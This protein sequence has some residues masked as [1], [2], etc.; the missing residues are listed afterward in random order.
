MKQYK[1]IQVALLAI[2]LFGWAG[3]SQ[4]EEEV[5]GNA[6]NGIVLNV[7][8]TGLISNEPSTRTEDTGFVTTFTQGDQIGLFAVKD[9]AILDEINNMPFTFNGSS[10][11]GKPIL[12]DERLAGVTFYAYYPYQPD[13]SGKTDLAGDDFFAPLVAGWELTTEQS[14]QKAYAK[15]DLMTSNAT[16]LIGENGNYTL[17]FQL[18]HRMSLVVVKLPSTRYIFTDAEGVAMPEETPYV[19]MPVDVA[20]YLD[21]VGEGNKIAPYYDAKQDEYRLLRKP[22][23]ENQIIGHYNDKQC[24]LDTAEKMKEGKYKRFVVDGGYK[25]VTHYLQV[26]D[27]YNADGSLISKDAKEADI[28]SDRC[29][30]VVCWVGNPQPSVLYAAEKDG[31]TSAQDVLSR[32]HPNC[33]NGLV[34]S[35]NT[36]NDKFVNGTAAEMR[37]W[38]RKN[39][40]DAANFIDL[41]GNFY[42]GSKT[43]STTVAERDRI[44]GYNNTRV[45]EAYNDANSSDLQVLQVL[46]T[47][48]KTVVAPAI[49]T[50][51]F[52]P[53]VQELRNMQDKNGLLTTLNN[54]IAK[55]QG[56]SIEIGTQYWSST[57]RN[58]S[59]MYYVSYTATSSSVNTG[60]KKVDARAYRFVL[61]F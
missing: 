53:S 52:L 12:Y 2:L 41:S 14:D 10:W 35:L 18:T 28:E 57:E 36:V 49:S 27:L 56:A 4:N 48:Q 32:E 38:Y 31:Y 45:I 25:E 8:D 51:W 33:V 37:I 19:A 5:P 24:T 54:Q 15:Q 34:V 43:T 22:S 9:G 42:D 3:C 21:N 1:L 61:A 50:N 55:V 39:F 40:T 20:F 7:T 59:N 30:G 26:G 47:Y 16:A 6:R 23:S 58:A 29:I 17:S 13:M 44:L 46:D 60:G 11:S